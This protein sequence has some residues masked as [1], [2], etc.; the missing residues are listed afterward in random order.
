MLS[1]PHLQLLTANADKLL[2]LRDLHRL[3][4]GKGKHLIAEAVRIPVRKH[5]ESDRICPH[6]IDR[7]HRPVP[8][9]GLHLEIHAAAS[10]LITPDSRQKIKIMSE[11]RLQIPQLR[12]VAYFY[13]FCH[14]FLLHSMV[15]F[16]CLKF[17]VRPYCY[18]YNT[19]PVNLICIQHDIPFSSCNS[20]ACGF[21]VPE[22]A[23]SRSPA[24]KG[25]FLLSKFTSLLY[26][27]CML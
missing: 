25:R 12:V 2:R 8:V 10:Y 14:L 6:K 3:L 23:H 9:V 26:Y 7:H 11:N 5:L 15:G 20:S 24:A 1:H 17:F 13:L 22:S 19:F 18:D 16:G 21:S 4:P 27:I